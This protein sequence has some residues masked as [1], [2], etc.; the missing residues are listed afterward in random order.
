[1]AALSVNKY[2]GTCFRCGKRVEA[3]DGLFQFG[4]GTRPWPWPQHRM[5]QNLPLV[6]HVTCNVIYNGTGIHYQFNPDASKEGF[7]DDLG[8]QTDLDP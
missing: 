6:E 4:D 3:G 5:Q 1:M 7:D 8:L 2:P